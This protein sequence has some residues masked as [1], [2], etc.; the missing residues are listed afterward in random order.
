MREGGVSCHSAPSYSTPPARLPALPQT[1]RGK[2]CAV[3]PCRH[4]ALP[5]LASGN[6]RASPRSASTLKHDDSYR[7]YP[8]V[9]Y[10]TTSC[11][12]PQACPNPVSN[13][14]RFPQTSPHHRTQSTRSSHMQTR[15]FRLPRSPTSSQPATK[16]A[17]HCSDAGSETQR[18][19][20]SSPRNAAKLPRGLAR[21]ARHDAPPAQVCPAISSDSSNRGTARDPDRVLR[22]SNGAC[23]ILWS[24]QQ[25]HERRLVPHR[26]MRRRGTRAC[27]HGPP[28]SSNVAPRLKTKCPSPPLSL[29]R[30]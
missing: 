5:L 20:P 25:L 14:P 23:N 8:S 13:T 21:R 29:K 2:Q 24:P 30:L 3:T 9:A 17:V 28:H 22:P 19:C 12:R 10:L 27:R 1:P 18:P 11:P 7:P 6:G 4:R 16:A 26:R 15:P